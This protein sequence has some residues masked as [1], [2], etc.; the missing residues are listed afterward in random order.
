MYTLHFDLRILCT[1]L[2]HSL[3]CNELT[4][5]L[6]V[7]FVY[8]VYSGLS[9]Y[10]SLSLSL[11]LLTTSKMSSRPTGRSTPP[12]GSSLLF[13]DT[14][15]TDEAPSS[16]SGQRVG[17]PELAPPY[18]MDGSSAGIRSP[19]SDF[20]MDSQQP[21]PLDGSGIYDDIGINDRLME[22]TDLSKGTDTVVISAALRVLARPS[23]GNAKYTQSNRMSARTD[24]SRTTSDNKNRVDGNLGTVP[25]DGAVEAPERVEAMQVLARTSPGTLLVHPE[26][27]LICKALRHALLDY[28]PQV[29][30][31]CLRLL[32]ELYDAAVPSPQTAEVYILVCNCIRRIIRDPERVLFAELNPVEHLFVQTDLAPPC[33]A[34][35]ADR[36]IDPE[37]AAKGHI[38]PAEFLSMI[39]LLNRWQCALPQYWLY[40]P[41]NILH[42]LLH[43]TLDL[44]LVNANV[45]S[46]VSPLQLFALVDPGAY[47]IHAWL[48][49]A[50]RREQWLTQANAQRKRIRPFMKMLSMQCHK[51]ASSELSSRNAPKVVDALE[52]KNTD[53]SPACASCHA[54]YAVISVR[55]TLSFLSCMFQDVGT[56]SAFFPTVSTVGNG[57]PMSTGDPMMSPSSATMNPLRSIRSPTS[58]HGNVASP[59]NASSSTQISKAKLHVPMHGNDFVPFLVTL[60][61]RVVRFHRRS[62]ISV[63]VDSPVVQQ[64]LALI[65]MI[66]SIMCKLAVQVSTSDENVSLFDVGSS[67]TAAPATHAPE[68]LFAELARQFVPQFWSGS[69]DDDA[70]ASQFRAMDAVTWH[71]NQ[72]FAHICL[73]L[74]ASSVLPRHIHNDIRL[75]PSV[76]ITQDSPGRIADG[77]RALLE[78]LR[79]CVVP[80]WQDMASAEQKPSTLRSLVLWHTPTRAILNILANILSRDAGSTL[81]SCLGV[82]DVLMQLWKA[83]SPMSQDATVFDTELVQQCDTRLDSTVWASLLVARPLQVPDAADMPQHPVVSFAGDHMQHAIPPLS[84]LCV[85]GAPWTA[86]QPH[87]ISHLVHGIQS[88]VSSLFMSMCMYPFG[89][90]ALIDVITGPLSDTAFTTQFHR[91]LAQCAKDLVTGWANQ[92]SESNSPLSLPSPLHHKYQI[93]T[94]LAE[95]VRGIEL[96][97]DAGV[98]HVFQSEVVEI[99][100]PARWPVAFMADALATPFAIHFAPRTRQLFSPQK[101]ITSSADCIIVLQCTMWLTRSLTCGIVHQGLQ[102]G[103]R[104]SLEQSL[105]MLLRLFGIAAAEHDDVDSASQDDLLY[106]GLR[107]LHYALVTSTDSQHW[108]CSTHT[109]AMQHIN[110]LSNATHKSAV[111]CMA[112]SILSLPGIRNGLGITTSLWQ[113]G[114]PIIIPSCSAETIETLQNSDASADSRINTEHIADIHEKMEQ[115]LYSHFLA[116]HSDASEPYTGAFLTTAAQLCMESI[117]YQCAQAARL[118]DVSKMRSTTADAKHSLP[119]EHPKQWSSVA[120]LIYDGWNTERATADQIFP[121]ACPTQAGARRQV[122]LSTPVSAASW[123]DSDARIVSTTPSGIQHNCIDCVDFAGSVLFALLDSKA[124]TDDVKEVDDKD[125]SLSDIWSYFSQHTL[126]G[127][128]LSGNVMIVSHDAVVAQHIPARG[129]VLQLVRLAVESHLPRLYSLFSRSTSISLT[130]ICDSWL[131]DAFFGILRRDNLAEFVCLSAGHGT[132]YQAWFIVAYLQHMHDEIIT[133]AKWGEEVLLAALMRHTHWYAFQFA[134]SKQIRATFSSWNKTHGQFHAISY[135]QQMHR[136]QQQYGE[137]LGV[138]CAP[139]TDDIV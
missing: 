123:R 136:L 59:H 2:T 23:T 16:V 73:C 86:Q 19:N 95:S 37:L 126:R 30:T 41:D 10:V 43:E 129:F 39:R 54:C 105:D 90:C 40:V 9:S 115:A 120:Q 132:E 121:V 100:A 29:R 11:S 34:T 103:V 56:R 21:F 8:H 128:S 47:W 53:Q 55:H 13:V 42:S 68:E 24:G 96:L 114:D 116:S 133:C 106:L 62:K 122:Q 81:L 69:S 18:S 32:A 99:C 60:L 118:Q 98:F 26:W 131:D 27:K 12:A 92:V 84:T 134:Q 87:T 52:S 77:V 31:P 137:L 66:R 28:N 107:A 83:V 67:S 51:F 38:S 108:I 102:K 1:R 97:H 15:P 46:R 75:L 139:S 82:N 17:T 57:V 50:A 14:N 64:Q 3:A 25:G 101:G 35:G 85:E 130:G 117:R 44:L 78:F 94:R 112:S 70:P 119:D 6:C 135:V 22:L 45:K 80:L 88:A 93:L 48:M 109:D 63:P 5:C 65:S 58:A 33:C 61:Q 111:S 71:V 104:E 74:S 124:N 113:M 72:S 91:M 49:S 79:S 110:S 76:A 127:G 7:V 36:T 4:L 20:D 125:L 138:T 89:Q